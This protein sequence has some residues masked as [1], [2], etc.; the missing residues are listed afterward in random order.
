MTLPA[1]VLRLGDVVFDEG[2]DLVLA[3]LSRELSSVLGFFF[4]EAP[5]CC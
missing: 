1:C 3:A 2:V 4:S 5:S